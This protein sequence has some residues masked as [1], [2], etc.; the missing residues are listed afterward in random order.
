MGI[1]PT[2]FELMTWQVLSFSFCKDSPVNLLCQQFSAL[3][4]LGEYI[5]LRKEGWNDF[6]VLDWL[7]YHPLL[8]Y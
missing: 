8:L 5:A 3:K 7:P 4:N 1:G 2:Y 6:G